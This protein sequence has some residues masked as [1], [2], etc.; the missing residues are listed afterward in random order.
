MWSSTL[1]C[2]LLCKIDI[3]ILLRD[4]QSIQQSAIIIASL[5]LL[6][7]LPRFPLPRF[8]ALMFGVENSTPAISTSE[9][10]CHDFHSRVFHYREFSFPTEGNVIGSV[11]LSVRP[12]LSTLS[13]EPIDIWMKTFACLWIMSGVRLWL[14]SRSKVKTQL[15]RPHLS[16]IL[17]SA[18][19]QLTPVVN[20]DVGWNFQWKKSNK[21]SRN[22][23]DPVFKIFIEIFRGHWGPKS[24]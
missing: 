24:S 23:H 14:K 16:A 12:F 5:S 8:P 21:V 22:F 4:F 18:Q 15:V 17:L 20:R 9:L 10:L 1:V 7:L 19:I 11:C 3:R 13:F 6:F 2:M